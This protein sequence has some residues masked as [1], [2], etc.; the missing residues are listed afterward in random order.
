[1]Y[2]CQ[3][4]EHY[5][6]TTINELVQSIGSKYIQSYTEQAF[7]Q[8]DRKRK[9]LVTGTPCQIDSFRRMIRKFRC[10]D[11]FVLMDF[12]CHCVPSMY[13]WI[14]YLKMVEPYIGKVSYASWRNKFEYGWH[15]SWLMG[16]DG[17]N[18]SCAMDWQ[19]PYDVIIKEKRTAI[20]SR[21][22]QGDI[23]YKLFL[24][25]V[26]HGPQCEKECKYKYDHSSAD[27]RIGDMWGK[28][29]QDDKKGVSALIAFTDKGKF[30]IENL[31]DVTL[32]DYP[33]EVT[34]EGQMRKNVHHK[35]IAFVVRYMLRHGYSLNGVPLKTIMFVQRVITTLKRLLLR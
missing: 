3:R 16:L 24:G 7:R 34:A 20:Q 28:T 4:A 35:E 11:N 32:I 13:A 18:D 22:S 26:C 8:I 25:D 10:E 9:Y 5:I 33:F 27:I 15:D 17:E 23:F 6:A 19:Q 2:S 1:M 14:G 12:F 31:K 21:M 30:V 29:Y